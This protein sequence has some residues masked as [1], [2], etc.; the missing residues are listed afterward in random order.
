LDE[1]DSLQALRAIHQ[2][3]E[4][5]FTS[6][7]PVVG[8]LVAHFRECW[9][10]VS[11]KWYVRPLLYQQNRVNQLVLVW[12]DK[13]YHRLVGY[14]QRLDEQDERLIEQDRDTTALAREVG[15]LRARV[16]QLERHIAALENERH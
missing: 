8:P 16:R 11:T 9:N 14:E 4:H 3:Q 1:E 15:E 6:R 5:P 13:F 12:L 2:L 7:L 10:S